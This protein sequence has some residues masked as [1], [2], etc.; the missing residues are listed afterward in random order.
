[1]GQIEDLIIKAVLSAEIHIATACKMLVPH[2]C[3]CFELYGFDVLIDSN[4]KPWLLEV[5]LSPSLARDAPLDLKI[6]ASMISDIVGFV[7]QDPLLRQ[8]C[9][10]RAGIDS[11]MRNPTQKPQMLD[12]A[13]SEDPAHSSGN[14]RRCAMLEK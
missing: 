10:D 6:K 8:P 12:P 11:R 5:N 9:P 2:H 7:C 1:M 13:L 4:L 3:N 14:P